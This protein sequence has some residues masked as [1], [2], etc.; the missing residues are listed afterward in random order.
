MLPAYSRCV[1]AAAGGGGWNGGEGR[2]PEE[3]EEKER[4]TDS[5]WSGRFSFHL[6]LQ[7][8]AT[9]S[10]RPRRTCRC[11]VALKLVGGN[12]TVMVE[13]IREAL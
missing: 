1:D 4:S 7:S 2:E 9:A 5:D 3:E 6:T 13:L 12:F 10:Q 11:F 8:P